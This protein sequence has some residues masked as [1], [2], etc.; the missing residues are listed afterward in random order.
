VPRVIRT[1]EQ[2]IRLLAAGFPEFRGYLRKKGVLHTARRL[3][4]VPRDVARAYFRSVRNNPGT[5]VRDEFDLQHGVETSIRVHP[6]DLR[7]DSPN[8]ISAVPYIPTPDG[9]LN[10]VFTGLEIKFEEFTFV[11]FGSGKGRVLL[12]ASDFPF[13]KIVGVEFSPELH[14]IACRN[15][16]SYKSTTRK[17]REITSVCMDFTEF[18]LPAGPVVGFL[19]NPASKAVTSVLAGNMMRALGERPRELWIV[20]VTPHDIFDG[21]RSLRKV[22]SGMYSGHPY[23][24]YTNSAVAGI[25]GPRGDAA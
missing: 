12:M 9:L 6:T 20:Y 22:S 21:E 4:L 2:Q 16:K 1:I 14:Q 23:C 10:Q 13:R 24:V 3:C 7:I 18:E 15:I 17:C 11:D 25:A 8:W 19:Y 5:D